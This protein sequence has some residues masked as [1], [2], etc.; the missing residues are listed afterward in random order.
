M[1]KA[2]PRSRAK[3]EVEVAET[4]ETVETIETVEIVE[5]DEA[6]AEVVAEVK[7]T[8]VQEEKPKAKE[9]PVKKSIAIKVYRDDEGRV[10][11]DAKGI[12]KR[13]AGTDSVISEVARQIGEDI[14][15]ANLI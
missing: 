14:V 10:V 3:Q 8:E 2:R 9:A 5:T 15:K 7:D 11:F 12:G 4:V 1:A 6:V 13:I